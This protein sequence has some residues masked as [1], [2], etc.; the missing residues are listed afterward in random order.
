M[1]QRGSDRMK[2]KSSFPAG[3]SRGQDVG[4]LAADQ[5]GP[6]LSV[7]QLAESPSREKAVHLAFLF[8]VQFIPEFGPVD[9]DEAIG[10]EPLFQVDRLIPVDVGGDVPLVP[11]GVLVKAPQVWRLR[12]MV[13]EINR[14]V[15]RVYCTGA[16]GNLVH[17]RPPSRSHDWVWLW[18]TGKTNIYHLV[19][20]NPG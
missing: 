10:N 15:V 19:L 6:V 14:V 7:I 5:Y 17:S 13:P 9:V 1:Y 2:S 12:L 8:F 4:Q 16:V 20:K 18:S 11:L 3:V